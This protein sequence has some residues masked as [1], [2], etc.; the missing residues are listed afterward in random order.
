[1]QTILLSESIGNKIL[2]VK[3]ADP[4]VVSNPTEYQKLAQSVS[5]LDEVLL[6]SQLL[7][8]YHALHTGIYFCNT[9]GKKLDKFCLILNKPEAI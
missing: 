1:M 4:D 6:L 8:P 7:Y 5:E 3:L 9:K 2:Q